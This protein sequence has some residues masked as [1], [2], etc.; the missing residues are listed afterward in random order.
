MRTEM[1]AGLT[2]MRESIAAV[3]TS[4]NLSLADMVGG[5]RGLIDAVGPNLLFL[6]VYIWVQDIAW[7]IV[8]ALTVCAFITLA[9]MVARQP[10]RHA[11]G[12]MALVAASGLMV[13]LTGDGTDFFLPELLHTGAVS[14]IL[15]LS[16][17]V[18]RPLMGV[19]LGPMV[20]GP[21]WR[22]NRT[23]HRA[24][25]WSTA[26]WAAA[27]VTRTVSK[28]PFYVADNVV[29]LGIIDLIT[30]IPLALVTLYF[31]MRMLRRAYA[32]VGIDRTHPGVASG[33]YSLRDHER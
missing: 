32:V 25:A 13:A 31:Q 7:A 20:S 11:I 15:L 22:T 8:A 10:I 28:I 29:A 26:I 18:R 16:L 30:G 9:R 27:A 3:I 23:L 2:R 4:P 24:Y 33:A 17:I 6:V 14:A 1:R 19:L 21:E 12:G 5:W